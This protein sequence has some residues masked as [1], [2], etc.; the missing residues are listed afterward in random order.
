MSLS[1][2]IGD[3]TPLRIFRRLATADSNFETAQVSTAFKKKQT[4]IFQAVILVF[5][6]FRIR[7]QLFPASLT[8]SISTSTSSMVIWLNQQQRHPAP[9]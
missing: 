4:N 7:L 8:A 9:V 6:P 3:V 1:S 2:T 5:P